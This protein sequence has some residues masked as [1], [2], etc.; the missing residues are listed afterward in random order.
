MNPASDVHNRQNSTIRAQPSTPMQLA[1]NGDPDRQTI[2]VAAVASTLRSDCDPSVYL[3]LVVQAGQVKLETNLPCT[4]QL[5]V[6]EHYRWLIGRSLRCAVVIPRSTISRHH[7]VI[8]Y[9]AYQGFYVMDVGSH[10]GTFLNRQQLL[11]HQSYAL[12]HGDC[13]ALSHQPI[14]INIHYRD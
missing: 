14:Q 3:N 4:E 6:N 7:A 11:P 8:G 2:E 10:N 13:L 9:D 1:L 12:N 5:S